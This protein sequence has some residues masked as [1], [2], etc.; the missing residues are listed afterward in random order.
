M[1][2]QTYISQLSASL[3]F[4]KLLFEVKKIDVRLNKTL[5][6]KFILMF[7][8]SVYSTRPSDT[9]TKYTIYLPIL[10]VR[11]LFKWSSVLFCYFILWL[12]KPGSKMSCILPFEIFARV[13][14]C[15]FSF[16]IPSFRHQ[17]SNSYYLVVAAVK[18]PKLGKRTSLGVYFSICKSQNRAINRQ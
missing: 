5:K 4:Y 10:L 18:I 3:F 15:K 8:D 13:C 7:F 16:F 2:N 11:R 1:D 9:G 14:F 17:D 12:A 6:L